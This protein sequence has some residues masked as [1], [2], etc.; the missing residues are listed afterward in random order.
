MLNPFIYSLRNKDIKS[1]ISQLYSRVI[2]YQL[3]LCLFGKQFDKINK[4]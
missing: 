3:W 2:W 1:V 4:I